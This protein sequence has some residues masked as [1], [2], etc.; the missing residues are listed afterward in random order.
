[1]NIQEIKATL[2]VQTL[3]LNNVKT[4][5]GVP[6][7]WYKNWD[8]DR[9]IAVIMHQDTLGLIKADPTI[10]SLGLTKPETKMSK[11]N[12]NEYTA[13]YI[14]NYKPADVTL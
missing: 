3:P 6:T 10:A 14:C 5:E 4:K 12:G 1:M 2:G 11:E 9:R 7:V 8:N 13:I